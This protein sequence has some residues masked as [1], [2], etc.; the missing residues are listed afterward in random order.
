MKFTG[1]LEGLIIGA[2]GGIILGGILGLVTMKNFSKPDYASTA[3]E[4]LN[5]KDKIGNKYQLVLQDKRTY[6]VW[7]PPE[8]RNE[9]LFCLKNN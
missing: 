2:V 5:I 1:K 7:I 3:G 8:E 4:C 9:K 6:E